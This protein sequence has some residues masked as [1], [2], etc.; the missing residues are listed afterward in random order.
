ML[1]NMRSLDQEKGLWVEASGEL[2][3]VHRILA[4]DHADRG[5]KEIGSAP[6]LW[7]SGEAASQQPTD[8]AID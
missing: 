7:R 6:I 4:Q 3:S 2:A 8:R 5:I 1:S